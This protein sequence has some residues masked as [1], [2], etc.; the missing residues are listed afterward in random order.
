MAEHLGVCGE[1]P[2]GGCPGEAG[3]PVPPGVDPD[4]WKLINDQILADRRLFGAVFCRYQ[5]AADQEALERAI[6]RALRATAR[7]AA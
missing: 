2:V 3:E 6:K 5:Q 7:T 4:T 1:P